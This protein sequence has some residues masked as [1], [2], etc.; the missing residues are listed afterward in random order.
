MLF[1]LVC[2]LQGAALKSTAGG[3]LTALTDWLNSTPRPEK[4]GTVFYLQANAL[5]R[6]FRSVGYKH[7]KASVLSGHGHICMGRTWLSHW[8]TSRR[9]H[10]TVSQVKI[11]AKLLFKG[12]RGTKIPDQESA[13]AARLTVITRT[14]LQANSTFVVAE[15]GK[16]GVLNERQ[17]CFGN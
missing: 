4:G 1:D 6:L 3:Q 5:T 8:E 7:M 17:T 2:D 16:K 14:R 11:K 13:H 9:S 12:F 10:Q 15:N